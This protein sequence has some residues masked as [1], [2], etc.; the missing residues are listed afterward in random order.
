MGLFG[1]RP[2]SPSEKE[3]PAAKPSAQPKRAEA[4]RAEDL[5]RRI[6]ELF[7]SEGYRAPMLPQAA[8]R[9]ISMSRNPETTID[10]VLRVLEEDPL[11]T[12]SVLRLVRSPV[13][14]RPDV[15]SLRDA[16]VRLGIGRVRELVME[17]VMRGKM[18]KAP[19]YRATLEGLQKHSRATAHLARHVSKEV[20][21]NDDN[22]FLT[23]LLHDVGI[24]AILAAVCDQRD[25]FREPTLQT[26][27]PAVRQVHE[28]CSAQLALAWE[29]PEDLVK[30]VA[31][32]HQ[33]RAGGE[34][35]IPSAVVCVGEAL[36]VQLGCSAPAGIDPVSVDEV[37]LAIRA[38]DLTAP[39]LDA[40]AASSAEILA[41]L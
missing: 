33:L 27:L 35:H 10:D 7:R 29:L 39:R 11:I 40:L 1:R 4:F 32:H 8:Q 2:R 34:V 13:Y 31:L 36:A 19:L 24:S 14:G 22:A 38:L 30:S 12:A 25:A 9:I 15:R 26:L 28:A 18:F 41:A 16:L 21:V 37:Q 3:R 5:E 23:G 17:V 6:L 20:G